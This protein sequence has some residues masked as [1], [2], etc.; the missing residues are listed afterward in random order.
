MEEQDIEKLKQERDEY[1]EGWKR[2][3]ADLINYK[4]EE[5]ERMEAMAEYAERELLMK[6]FPILDNLERAAKEI[7]EDDREEQIWKGFLQIISQWRVFL[8]SR[9][10][11][12]IE[13]VGKPF[14][15]AIHEAVGEVE[16]GESGIVAEELEKGYTVQG[17]L[18]RPAKVK[19]TK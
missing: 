11:E 14:N 4:K 7:P 9:G 3:K 18:L 12:E 19:V 17:R 1:L 2:A 5:G 8:K 13:T 16:G 10:A 6:V 15:P